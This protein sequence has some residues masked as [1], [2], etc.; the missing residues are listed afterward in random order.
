[1]RRTSVFPACLAMACL[2]AGSLTIT[3]CGGSPGPETAYA[4]GTVKM[5]G[6]PVTSGRVMFYPAESKGDGTGKPASGHLDSNGEFELSTYGSGD[7][8][9]VGEH[10][11]TVLDTESGG[12][13]GPIG[14]ANPEKVSV[15]SGEDNVYDIQLTMIDPGQRQDREEEDNEDD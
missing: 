2:L 4:R 8:A 9:V 1:M 12:E 6:E 7:G 3:G 10:L 14:A 13:A 15:K 5:N 11:V